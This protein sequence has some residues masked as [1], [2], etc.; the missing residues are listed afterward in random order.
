VSLARPRAGR[1]GATASATNKNFTG[2]SMS[3]KKGFFRIWRLWAAISVISS[4]LHF[5]GVKIQ[6]SR[7]LIMFYLKEDTYEALVKEL[8]LLVKEI[9]NRTELFVDYSSNSYYYPHPLHSKVLPA[10][11]DLYLTLWLEKDKEE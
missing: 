3:A 7:S 6:F 1:G 2:G 11:K 10:L 8:Y 5:F 9:L 4:T